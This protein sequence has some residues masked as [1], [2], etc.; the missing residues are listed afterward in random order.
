MPADFSKAI[1]LDPRY[2]EAYASRGL[3]L[4]ARHLDADSQKDFDRYLQL[5]PAAKD[6]LDQHIK[7]AKYQR[8]KKPK[9]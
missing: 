3:I 9:P 1:E 2:T 6:N 4:L 5:N 7:Y 8:T